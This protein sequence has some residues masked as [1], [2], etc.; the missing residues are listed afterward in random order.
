MASE[1]QMYRG[2]VLWTYRSQSRLYVPNHQPIYVAQTTVD[3]FTST[4]KN[5]NTKILKRA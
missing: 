2:F 3:N 1:F 4:T 5:L